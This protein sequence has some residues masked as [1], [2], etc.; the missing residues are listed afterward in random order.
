[1]IPEIDLIKLNSEQFYHIVS[2]DS[3]AIT[4]SNVFSH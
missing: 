4:R 3:S 1:M 2:W